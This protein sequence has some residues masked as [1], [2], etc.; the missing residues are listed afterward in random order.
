MYTWMGHLGVDDNI[1]EKSNGLFTLTG[2]SWRVSWRSSD[3]LRPSRPRR[4]TTASGSVWSQPRNPEIK[5]RSTKTRRGW[6]EA[7]PPSSSSTR[8]RPTSTPPATSRT[9][10]STPSS[11]AS[12]QRPPGSWSWLASVS[13][14]W[15]I[16][17]KGP[18]N[19]ILYHNGQVGEVQSL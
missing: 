13:P 16:S 8:A 3:I 5:V 2:P 9:S 7:A 19:S 14:V 1:P 18:F 15:E 11:P 10:S 6:S 17:G 12:A 4:T